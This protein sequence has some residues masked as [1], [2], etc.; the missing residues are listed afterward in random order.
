MLLV[1]IAAT[2]SVLS[3]TALA[4]AA[5]ASL[6]IGA[7]WIGYQI[8][9]IY[10]AGIFAS[11]LSGSLVARFSAEAMIRAELAMILVGL[12]LLATAH[13]AA[14]LVGSAL[15]G[16]AYGINNP[17]S[18]Q[19]LQ[20]VVTMRNRSLV[21]SIKQAGVPLGAMLA[22]AGLPLVALAVGGWNAAILSLMVLPAALLAA[23]AGRAALPHRRRSGG[24][25]LRRMQA[26]QRQVFVDPAL[27]TLAILGC[28]YSAMQ[29]TVTAFAVVSL[30]ELGWSVPA[31]GL[32]GAL[33]QVAGAVGRVGWGVVA[34]RAGAFHVLAALG[35]GGAAMSLVLWWQP[36][37]AAPALLVTMIAL[38]AC[39]SGWNGV[40]L[41]AIARSAP[42]GQ[43]G[44]A[45]G[46]ILAYTFLGAIL[47]PSLFAAI[48]GISGSYPACFALFGLWGFA[49]G[50]LSAA[51]ARRSPPVPS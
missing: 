34:D 40:L 33:L 26:E 16:V 32:V 43:A 14:M 45:T 21:F 4:P 25:I 46:A 23:P 39:A 24:S 5:S 11:L 30:V 1:Q 50:I 18:S 6:G 2:S 47:G 28:L 38:G 8:G 12:A 13:P 15:L 27:R 22:N 29:L 19:I 35:F 48:F 17:A 31:A 37:L 44:A 42:P 3:L 49:G 9:L 41:A 51:E 7:H 36:V 10:F 20:R